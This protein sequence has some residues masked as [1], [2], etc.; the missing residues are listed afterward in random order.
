MASI[1]AN[2]VA[3]DDPCPSLSMNQLDDAAAPS[4]AQQVY[5]FPLPFSSYV[6]IYI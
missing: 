4:Y 1:T 5:S 2:N 6:F 3:L